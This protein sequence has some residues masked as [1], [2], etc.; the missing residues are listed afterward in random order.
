M[1]KINIPVKALQRVRQAAKETHSRSASV[2]TT[3][4]SL[5]FLV[6]EGKEQQTIQLE[7]IKGK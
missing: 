3:E 4:N 1:N 2:Y 6:G 5:V 7:G